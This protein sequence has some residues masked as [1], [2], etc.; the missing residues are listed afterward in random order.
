[1]SWSRRDA[2][3]FLYKSFT[4]VQCYLFSSAYW[5]YWSL[6]N[7]F[8]RSFRVNSLYLSSSEAMF[9]NDSIAEAPVISHKQ[10]VL[11]GNSLPIC[12]CISALT[13]SSIRSVTGS[14]RLQKVASDTLDAWQEREAAFCELGSSYLVTALRNY[15]TGITTQWCIT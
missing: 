6:C 4:L 1:M 9:F 8:L 3:R 5:L 11:L 15:V 14:T 10:V 7:Q 2:T 13:A 12:C